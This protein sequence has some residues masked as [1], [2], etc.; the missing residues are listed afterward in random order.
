VREDCL[1]KL[2]WYVLRLGELLSRDMA[3]TR[4]GE[5]DGGAQRVI[6]AC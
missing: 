4:G 6:G 5:L 2:A 1:K 3:I